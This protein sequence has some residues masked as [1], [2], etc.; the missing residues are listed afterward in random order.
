MYYFRTSSFKCFRWFHTSF[1]F[2]NQFGNLFD[3]IEA[4]GMGELTQTLD[5]L[6]RCHRLKA[7]QLEEITNS[8][9][10]W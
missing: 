5:D 8:M 6:V 10:D 3:F 7:N 1:G 9:T 2:E 4:E